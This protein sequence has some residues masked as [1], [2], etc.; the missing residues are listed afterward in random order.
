M[1]KRQ[2]KVGDTVFYP[3][4][5]V[6]VIEAVEDVFI[7]GSCDSC[8][9]IRIAD[10]Q[11]TVKVPQG[12]IQKSGLRPLLSG[13]KLKELYK[14]LSSKSNRR[15]TGGNWTDRCRELERRINGGSCLELGEVVRDLMR[16][17]KQSG[18]S[19]EESM[20]LKTATNFLAN[21]VAA[22]QGIPTETAIDR[23][24]SHVEV[25]AA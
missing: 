5:G 8:F 17:K 13:R 3:S 21:E 7:S 9:V 20:L 16:W 19:F 18:L 11:M 2:F 22:I 25:R 24:R 15:V 4:A 12:N 1:R 6:G 10:T 23:I 14:I